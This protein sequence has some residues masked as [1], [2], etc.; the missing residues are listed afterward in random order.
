M[1]HWVQANEKLAQRI[2]QLVGTMHAAWLFAILASISLP[3]ALASKN[4]LVI[5]AWIAQTFLQ[6]VLLPIIMVGQNVTA[7]ATE[8]VIRETHDIVAN[9]L[10]AIRSLAHEMHTHLGV[11]AND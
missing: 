8:A 7:A 4:A 1:K 10:A 2:T 3:A 5:V 11:G 6:L 9:E